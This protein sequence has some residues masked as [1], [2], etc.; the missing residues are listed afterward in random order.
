MWIYILKRKPHHYFNIKAPQRRR[1]PLQKFWRFSLYF[2]FTLRAIFPGFILLFSAKKFCC[3]FRCFC[4]RSLNLSE[5]IK[6]I[7][8]KVFHTGKTLDACQAAYKCHEHWDYC[9]TDCEWKKSNTDSNKN[10]GYL[11]FSVTIS[12]TVA[13]R[14]ITTVA[15]HREKEKKDNA[16]ADN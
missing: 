4:S 15:I 12:I 11:L 6:F 1:R 14:I 5:C 13:R 10:C 16:T 2:A 7:A 8:I 9:A 3:Y